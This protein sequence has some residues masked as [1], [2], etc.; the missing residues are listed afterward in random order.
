MTELHI[1]ADDLRVGDV[2]IHGD[3]ET[4]VRRLDRSNPPTLI[5]NPGDDDQIDGYPW[6]H[7]TVR[8]E[9]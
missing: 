6:Q 5:T 1:P 4:T 9:I 7:V 2:I 8:R 3:G